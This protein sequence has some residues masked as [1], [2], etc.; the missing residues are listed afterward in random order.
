VWPEDIELTPTV[1]KHWYCGDGHWHNSEANNCI[2]I[3]MANEI[4]NTNKI[5][6]IFRNVGIQA[7]SNYSSSERKG[8]SFTCNADFTVEQSKELWEYMGKPL[9]DFEYKWPERYH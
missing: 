3:A 9:P 1:L 4:S 6:E 5:D 7:P 2:S 8:G